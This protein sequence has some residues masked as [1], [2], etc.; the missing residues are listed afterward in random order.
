[1]SKP[2]ELSV[3]ILAV[4][5]VLSCAQEASNYGYLESASTQA[6]EVTSEYPQIIK[7]ILPG[8]RG[9]CTGSVI[10]PR[11]VLTAAHCV[12]EE[13]AYRVYTSAGVRSTYLVENL[14][15]GD[16]GDSRD[17]A[18]LI[19]S[20]DLPGPY[21][22]IGFNSVAISDAVRLVGFGCND[23]DTRLGTGSKRTGTN[24]IVNI[25]DFLVLATPL[26]VPQ[27][28]RRILGPDN[29][30]GSCFGDSGGPLLRFSDGQLRVVGVAH[31][32][33]WND[34]QL[35]S[36]YVNLSRAEIVDFL[37]EVDG[38]YD[39]GLFDVCRISPESVGC[40]VDQA[41]AGINSLLSW[42][43]QKIALLF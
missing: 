12:T 18:L 15:N 11:A 32:G 38:R 7:V 29:L 22:P 39:L 19:F 28:H 8:G 37:H 4:L 41:S 20:A 23:L 1:M 3:L 10:S 26:D 25:D 5:F 43:W 42:I 27:S 21:L 9:L 30:A 40:R 33:G 34:T 13:G 36:R 31:A 24:R 2:A 35:V 17:V 14:G 16:L 6:V